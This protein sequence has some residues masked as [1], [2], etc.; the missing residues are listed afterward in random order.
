[1]YGTQDGFDLSVTIPAAEL[2]RLRRRVDYLEAVLIQVMR[3]RQRIKEWFSAAELAALRLPG[4]PTTRGSV[5]RHARAERWTTRTV[6]GQGG[7]RHEF[8]F[9]SLPRRA[10]DALVTLVVAPQAAAPT[11]ERAEQVP[12][13]PKIEP[14]PPRPQ[15]TAPPWLLPLMRAVRVEAPA[16]V[17][18][19]FEVLPRYLPKGIPCPTFAEVLPELQRLGMVS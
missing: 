16:N 8:H 9:S 12:E 7:A 10:F 18:E 1:M 5:T 2:A 6:P 3:E 14:P 17:R 15:N 13:L 11:P 19:A 4:L